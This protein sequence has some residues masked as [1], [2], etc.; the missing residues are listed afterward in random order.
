MAI[1]LRNFEATILVRNNDTNVEVY[2]NKNTVSVQKNS[3]K[4]LMII[5]GAY[6]IDLDHTKVSIPST[7]NVDDLMDFIL[8]WVTDSRMNTNFGDLRTISAP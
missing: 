8:L 7:T 3:S 5:S 1:E 2:L 4:S 6:K